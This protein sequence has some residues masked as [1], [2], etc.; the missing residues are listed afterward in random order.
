LMPSYAER[1]YKEKCDE[2]S[3]K[4]NMYWLLGC[5]ILQPGKNPFTVWNK[6][7]LKFWAVSPQ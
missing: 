6:S 5:N 7:N 4:W 2:L 1:A 3:I